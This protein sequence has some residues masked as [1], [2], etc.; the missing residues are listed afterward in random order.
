MEF[1]S[2]LIHLS[3]FVSFK[4]F[5]SFCSF[6]VFPFISRFSLSDIPVPATSLYPSLYL[7]LFLDIPYTLV[8]MNI[9][10]FDHIL[11]SCLWHFFS[12]FA[13]FTLFTSCSVSLQTFQSFEF[14]MNMKF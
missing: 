10:G 5:S 1:K 4:V 11:H 14:M 13:N 6:S 12:L 2:F 7:Q 3:N 9:L 8:F